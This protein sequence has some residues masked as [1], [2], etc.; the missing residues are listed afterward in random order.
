MEGELNL[1]H[2]LIE[3]PVIVFLVASLL[4]L[5]LMLAISHLVHYLL[6]KELGSVV[7]NDAVENDVKPNSGF[8]SDQR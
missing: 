6:R 7:K 8:G 3:H 2:Q 4:V 5:A 1:L